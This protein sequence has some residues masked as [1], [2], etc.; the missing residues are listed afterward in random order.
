MLLFASCYFYMAFVP[1]Y[2]LILLGLILTDFLAGLIIERTKGKKKLF[3][4]LLSVV[5]NIGALCFFKYWNF[6]SESFFTLTTFLGGPVTI[7][8]LNILLPI[9]LSFHTFQSLA[10][11]VEVY[12]GKWK[13]EK[14]LLVYSL[15]VLFYPQMVA[16]PIERPSGLLKSLHVDHSFD[17]RRLVSGLVL[18]AYG[19][20]KKIVI[21]DRLSI[22]VDSIYKNPGNFRGPLL[23]LA[24]YF[25]TFQIYC[26][27]SGYVD[28]ARGAARVMGIELCENFKRP[29][30]AN[31]I[32]DFWRRWHISLSFWFRDYV[33]IPLG[34]NRGGVTQSRMN[35]LVVFLLSGLWHG[36]NWTFVIWGVIHG[37]YFLFSDIFKSIILFPKFIIGRR[38]LEVIL[39]FNMVAFAW[40]F[41]R[42]NSLADAFYITSHLFGGWNWQPWESFQIPFTFWNL[43]LSGLLIVFLLLFEGRTTVVRL[44]EDRRNASSVRWGVATGYTF[45]FTL[46]CAEVIVFLLGSGSGDA[47][48][49]AQQ[50]IYFQ[51]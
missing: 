43:I 27:F 24:T 39:T 16:G 1:K 42:A 6:F 49:K 8:H 48:V 50:F 29:Y 28:I 37:I 5:T 31:S 19:F 7:P 14:N 11:I 26:D 15:Y 41:F 51:F 23:V 32:R 25:F 2:I 34:G 44:F 36:A 33:Y 4:L 47:S 40:I 9:G 21:A 10:Y 38:L 3:W 22:L 30:F 46:I 13:A 45:I 18:M 20:F 35:I 17:G 12:R